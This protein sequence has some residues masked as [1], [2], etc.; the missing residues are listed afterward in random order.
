MNDQVKNPWG[1]P[2]DDTEEDLFVLP[3]NA[4]W[5]EGIRDGREW[6]ESY[7]QPQELE[8]AFRRAELLAAA[9]GVGGMDERKFPGC[10]D[11][12]E[13]WSRVYGASDDGVNAVWKSVRSFYLDKGTASRLSD[14]TYRAGFECGAAAFRVEQVSNV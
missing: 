6:A 10:R 9:Q 7:A 12:A 8:S 13:E 4:E 1:G 5:G 3:D 2:G 14:D 11:Q